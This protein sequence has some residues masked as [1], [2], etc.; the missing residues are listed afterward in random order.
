MCGEG[1]RV[2][3]TR[4]TQQFVHDLCA[5]IEV[6]KVLRCQSDVSIIMT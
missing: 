6:S 4:L 2:V 3:N 1:G 5:I